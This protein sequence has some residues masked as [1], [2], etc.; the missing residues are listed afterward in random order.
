MST[1]RWSPRS[2][3]GRAPDATG[4]TRT[5]VSGPLRLFSL[6]GSREHTLLL[7]AGDDATADDVATFERAAD[8]AV[9][10]AHGRIDVYLIAAPNAD[11][12]ITALPVIRDRDGDFARMYSAVGPSVYVVRPDGYLGFASAVI[13]TDNLV[14]HLSSTFR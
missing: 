5:S 4:L 11:V 12:D 14:T 9:R 1:A 6:L 2:T 10:A 13:D 3:G 7:Y 8:A